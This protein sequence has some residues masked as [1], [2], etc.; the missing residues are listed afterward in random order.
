MKLLLEIVLAIFLHPIAVI[1]LFINLLGRNDIGTGKKIVRGI[2]GLVWGS[3]RSSTWW[4][5]RA[6]SG[7]RPAFAPGRP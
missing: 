2:V 1:L 5:A 4:W 3:G 7:S 6:R